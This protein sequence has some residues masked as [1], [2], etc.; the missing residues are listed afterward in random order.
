MSVISTSFEHRA[1]RRAGSPLAHSRLVVT[2]DGLLAEYELRHVFK[3]T[4]S[5]AM[6]AVYSFPVPLDAAFMGMEATLADEHRVARVL[7]ASRAQE[8]YDDAIADGDSAVLLE[9]L[10]PGLL[11]V[12]LGNLLSGEEGEIVLRFAA[13]LQIAAGQARFSLPLVQRP[14]YGHSYL[15]EAAT[16]HHDFAVE[17]PL[18]AEIRVCGLLADAAV[19]SASHG[20]RFSRDHDG[21]LLEVGHAQ[22]DRDLVLG[23]ELPADTPPQA[24][25]VQHEAGTLGLVSWIV[26]QVAGDG[27]PMD[28]CLVLDGSGSM[29]GDA[30]HQSREALKAVTA[31]L[32]E[33]DRIQV[34]RFGSSVVP[35]FRRPMRATERVRQS[36]DDLVSSVDANLGGTEMGDAL[37][38]AL[39]DLGSLDS[40]GRRQVVILVTDGAVYPEELR[41]ARRQAARKGVRIFVVA[42]GSS[43]GVDALQPLAEVTQGSLERAVPAEPIDQAVMRHVERA[44]RMPLTIR[45]DWEGAEDY[46]PLGTVYP[47]DGFTAIALLKPEVQAALNLEIDGSFQPVRLPAAKAHAAAAAW[48]GQQRYRCSLPREREELALAYGL[49]VDETSA[50][51]IRERAEDEKAA[52][53]P[54]VV[55]VAHMVPEGMVLHNA[56]ALPEVSRSMRAF[57]MDLDCALDS[58]ADEFAEEF[59]LL[60]PLPRERIELVEASLRDALDTLLLTDPTQVPTLDAL[61]ALIDTDLHEEVRA[62]IQQGAWA[63]RDEVDFWKL[64]HELACQG[65]GKPLSLAQKA[66]LAEGLA[67]N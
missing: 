24:L 58:V 44:R 47:G 60:T 50:V 28:L 59:E 66:R 57:P 40:T 5:S 38:H 4:G 41:D 13:A 52:G 11:C 10:E 6:E 29:S 33:Q 56:V 54:T 20:A 67:G 18:S 30:I 61:L 9:L 27:L 48:G 53:L 15:D 3:N 51:L 8:N 45:L 17:H 37:E 63:M 26:P 55:P 64:L 35:L 32:E 16:V 39:S 34:M 25:S 43:A 31:A 42:V 7:P 49:I 65:I 62:Y 12:N 19:H 22:L 14:R 36:L 46:L 21:L 23:F 1:G 2:I